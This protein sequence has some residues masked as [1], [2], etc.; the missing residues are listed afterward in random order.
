MKKKLVKLDKLS[1]KKASVY[2]IWVE[3]LQKTSFEIF[4]NENK[5]VLLSELNDIL[6]RLKVIGHETGARE[7]FFKINEGKPGDG[8]CALYDNPDRKLRLY[9]IKYGTLIVILGGGG[10]KNVK[11][12]QQNNKLTDENYFLRELSEQITER[13]KE[14]EIWFTNNN[15]DFD[16][17][18]VFENED[19]E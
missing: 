17:N 10:P 15:M 19:D 11:K 2:S 16:G 12:L 5:N 7:Q 8:V 13:I 3:E 6:S 14:G 9:C 1:G 4:L 18:L